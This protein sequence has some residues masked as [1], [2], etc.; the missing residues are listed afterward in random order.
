MKT[1]CIVHHGYSLKTPMYLL[2]SA[3]VPLGVRVPQVGNRWANVYLIFIIRLILAYLLVD[4][5]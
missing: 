2:R 5:R 4:I 1:P 3:N